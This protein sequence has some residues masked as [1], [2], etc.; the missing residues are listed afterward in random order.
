VN[1]PTQLEVQ[2][3]LES[4][5]AKLEAGVLQEEVGQYNFIHSQ[6]L[7]VKT[8]RTYYRL[9]RVRKHN[10]GN[11]FLGP[12]Q[13]HTFAFVRKSDGAIF[14]A[15]TRTKPETRTKSAIRGYVTDENPEQYF[16]HYGVLYA[17]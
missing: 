16:S 13:Y 8:G 15:A 3:A 12:E 14:R 10:D 5:V 17:Q 9:V 7:E 2:Y 6:W 1:Q 11:F 4:L